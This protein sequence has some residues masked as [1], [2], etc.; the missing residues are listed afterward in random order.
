MVE[1]HTESGVQVDLTGKPHFRFQDLPAYKQIK[2]QHLKEMDYCWLHDGELFLLEVKSYADALAEIRRKDVGEQ[3]AGKDIRENKVDRQKSII[4]RFWDK[5][6]PKISDSLLM[7]SAS[8]VGTL[9]GE[10]LSKQFTS[11]EFTVP[12]RRISI[13]IIVEMPEEQSD[14]YRDRFS[15]IRKRCRVVTRGQ[16][17]LFDQPGNSCRLFVLTPDELNNRGYPFRDYIHPA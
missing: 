3:V 17:A 5:T 4:K 1:I 10:A 7:F 8:W 15:E 13:I 14:R 6:I 16:R 9:K 2:G 11:P 12:P